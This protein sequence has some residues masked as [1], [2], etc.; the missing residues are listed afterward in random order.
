[1]KASNHKQGV[2]ELQEVVNL[3]I[4]SVAEESSSY[5]NSLS[6]EDARNTVHEEHLKAYHILDELMK[7]KIKVDALS[8][9]VED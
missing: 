3:L 6:E 2:E 4:K 5:V 1:M 7:V 8:K 9:Y